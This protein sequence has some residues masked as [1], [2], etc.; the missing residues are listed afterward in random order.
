VRKPSLFA[1][2][3]LLIAAA[4]LAAEYVDQEHVVAADIVVLEQPPAIPVVD[5]HAHVGR[6]EHCY[7][8]AV[9]TMDNAGVKTTI[10]MH[11]G[12]GERLDR[13]LGLAARHPGRFLIFCGVWVE[14]D[15]RGADNVGEVFAAQLEEAHKKGAAGFGEVI[16]WAMRPGGLAWDDPRLDPMWAK[17]E[18]LKM[19]VNW[20][21]ADPSRYWRPEHPLNTLESESYYKRAPLKF[22][23]LMQQNRVLEKHPDLIVIAAHSNYLADMIPLLEWRFRTFPNYHCDLSATIGE[24]GRVPEEFKYMV[25]EYADRFF[26]GTDAGYRDESIEYFGEGDVDVAA[27][28]MAAF[29]LSHYMFLGTGQRMLPIPFNGNYGRYFIGWKDNYTRY[30][31][32]GANLPTDVLEKIYYKNA[33]R[34]FGI[35]VEGWEPP[36]PPYW[37]QPWTSPQETSEEE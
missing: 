20:H 11:G 14:R 5:A 17:L 9:K 33:E 4:A 18:E 28:N 32:D 36:K 31:H 24:W 1:V 27:H 34:L 12:T 15:Q 26:Y 23:L 2:A 29:H 6:S 22:E 10:V 16:R 37:T 3:L 21:V 13:H 8:L 35:E 19:P 25:T 30:A 7:D